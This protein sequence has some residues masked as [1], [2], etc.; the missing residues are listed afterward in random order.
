MKRRAVRRRGFR[1][2]C[3]A[4][5]PGTCGVV[6]RHHGR[7]IARGGG[8][9][10]AAIDTVVAAELNRRGRRKLR[11]MGKRIRVRVV[12]TLPG[13]T[14]RSRRITVAQ[15]V[16]RRF[17]AVSTGWRNPPAKYSTAV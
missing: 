5:R 1:V 4:V 16:E 2:T 8:D 7:R 9:V 6:V 11:R 13:E 15:V 10:P 3:A 12:V 14:A 17:Q